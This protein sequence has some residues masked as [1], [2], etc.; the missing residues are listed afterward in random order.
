MVTIA[1]LKLKFINMIHSSKIVLCYLIIK[2][3]FHILINNIIHKNISPSSIFPLM[4]RDTKRATTIKTEPA[5]PIEK[6]TE[7]LDGRSIFLGKC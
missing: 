4:P 1:D 3:I 2:R 5:P 6:K 7:I